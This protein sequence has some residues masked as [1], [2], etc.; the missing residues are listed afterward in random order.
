M[1]FGVHRQ[2]ACAPGPLGSQSQ[3]FPVSGG[4]EPKEAIARLFFVI[5]NKGKDLNLLQIQDA[6]LRSA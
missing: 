5:L 6:L 3:R 2:D 4:K 1:T